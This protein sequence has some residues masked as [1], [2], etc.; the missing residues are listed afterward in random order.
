[1]K[2]ITLLI[3]LLTFNLFFR[4]EEDHGEDKLQKRKNPKRLSRPTS[5]TKFS[6]NFKIRSITKFDKS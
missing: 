5:G 4:A 6:D 2:N 1:M 3:N